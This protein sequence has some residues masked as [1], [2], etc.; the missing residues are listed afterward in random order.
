MYFYKYVLF[1]RKVLLV[2]SLR[3]VLAYLVGR[4]L[5]PRTSQV[6]TFSNAY[7]YLKNQNDISV[8]FRSITE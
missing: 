7:L 6:L 4:S 1:L 2:V 8:F 5:S 3:W